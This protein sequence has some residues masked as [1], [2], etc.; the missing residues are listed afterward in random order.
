[1]LEEKSGV[2]K[3]I[4]EVDEK[5]SNLTREEV[6]VYDRQIRLWGVESQRKLRHAKVL[7]AGIN[8]LGNEVCKNVILAGVDH[9][10]I[11]DHRQLTKDDWEVQFLAKQE[12]IGKNVRFFIQ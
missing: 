5:S 1:M 12:D 9:M 4:S 6:A 2:P 10:T 8:G 3:I 11:L 7:V